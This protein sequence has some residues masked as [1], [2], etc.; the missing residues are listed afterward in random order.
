MDKTDAVTQSREEMMALLRRYAEIEHPNRDHPALT[1]KFESDVKADL[2]AL[3]TYAAAIRAE[4]DAKWLA[5]VE[6]A[7]KQVEHGD[8]PICY[9]GGTCNRA[10]GAA[11]AALDRVAQRIKEEG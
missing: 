1:W 6:D 4:R 3:D 10:P 5:V 9:D 11:D 8:A 2:E 7:R